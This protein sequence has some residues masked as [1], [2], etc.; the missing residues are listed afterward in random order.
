M[1][2]RREIS[3]QQITKSQWLF[4]AALIFSIK[5]FIF[6][7]DPLPMFFLGDSA[8]YIQTALTGWIPPDRSFVYGF[9]IEITA[10]AAH[11]L[12]SLIILQVFISGLNAI[13]LAYVLQKFFTVDANLA[14]LC[15]Y[16][17]ALEPLQLMFERYVM[18][19]TFSLFLFVIYL[20]L[21]FHYLMR[22]CL[23]LLALI[24]IAG[25]AIISFRLSFLPIILINAFILPLIVVPSIG[26]KYSVT[27]ISLKTFFQKVGLLKKISITV[28]FHI[29]VS[30][31]LT[32]ALHFSYKTLNGYLSDKPHAYQYQD[33]IFLL[34]FWGP[35]VEPIDFPRHDLRDAVF[36]NLR[37]NLKDRHQRSANRWQEGGII[38]NLNRAI[39]DM[40]EAN[41]VAKITA[42]NALKRDPI[43]IFKLAASSFVDY[44]NLNLLQASLSNSRGEMQLPEY[45]LELLHKNFNLWAND[46]PF[47][48]TFT[49]KYYYFAWPWYLFLLFTPLFGL[50][51]LFMRYKAGCLNEFFVFLCSIILVLMASILIEG[52]TIRYLH[53]LGW[54]VFLFIGPFLQ[55]VFL[56]RN[57][58]FDYPQQR[59][60]FVK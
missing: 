45:F 10:V 4:F 5:F 9:L 6:C 22:P 52:P 19:E 48:K 47:L 32:Y 41:E 57:K 59:K 55:N 24:Q 43:G 36:N 29:I 20:I 8:S 37:F 28:I 17:C 16:M 12:T 31:G 49:N 30:I 13:F 58:Y 33:G 50:I 51:A 21:C 18:T 53:S 38:S 25:V 1:T 2:D 7:T 3:S 40:V 34:S 23:M 35:I 54:L 15:G 60:A 11:S 26:K 42:L 39:P 27:F 56:N 44:W 46:L 14:F